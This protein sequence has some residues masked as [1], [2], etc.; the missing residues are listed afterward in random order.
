MGFVSGRYLP[1][2]S[3]LCNL[4]IH[5]TAKESPSHVRIAVNTRLLLKGRL[6]GI[7]SFTHNILQQ[8]VADHP[9]H[10]FIFLFD[11]P[12]SPEFQ[13]ASNVTPVFAGPPA[14]HPLL[15][16]IW[17]EYV[18]PRLLRKHKVDVFLS[19]DGFL[20]LGAS[21]PQVAVI[22]DLNFEYYPAFFTP[23]TRWF[24]RTFFPRYARVATRIATVSEFSK[25]DLV[26]LY[27]VSPEKIDVI[28]NGVDAMYAPASSAAIN[29]FTSKHTAGE[30][31]FAFVGG[32]YLRKNLS[33]VLRAFDEFKRQTRSPVKFVLAGRSYRETDE[34]F[35]LHQ[36]LAC[37]DDIIFLGRV[38]PAEAVPII[39]SGAL[40]LVYVSH[41]EGFGLP[42][43]ESMRC[44]TPVI[45][46]NVTAMPEIAGDAA[47]LVDPTS[48]Q[49]IA[50]A[51]ATM[52][53]SDQMRQ[54][55]RSKGLE[56]SEKFTWKR[57]ADALW[58]S[59]MA[60]KGQ[61]L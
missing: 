23:M 53:S 46:G 5:T 41:F 48:V 21:I 22:H 12:W 19:P 9:E 15:F 31:Y 28:Y 27:N 59:I 42:I 33:M 55:L 54:E 6:E 1:S 34:L 14:R 11:R 35:R 58:S 8:L 50:D 52:A 51:M 57:S 13:Y 45:T 38:E 49:S 18:V 29:D 2:G 25:S 39:L 60:A 16:Y 36:T 20:P 10:E 47:L 17:F 32:L 61:P 4:S 37:K 24:Y 30:D 3:A 43:I 40:S 44:G 26:N 56:Q 7:G